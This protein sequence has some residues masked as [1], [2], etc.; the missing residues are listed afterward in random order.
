MEATQKTS[1]KTGLASAFDFIVSLVGMALLGGGL[2]VVLGGASTAAEAIY[3]P[4]TKPW[5]GVCFAISALI[6]IKKKDNIED[7]KTLALAYIS[8]AAMLFFGPLVFETL[9]YDEFHKGEFLN[10]GKWLILLV[11][12]WGALCPLALVGQSKNKER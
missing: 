7:K 6:F 2:G 11:G 9:F 1:G 10:Q 5:L 8:V 4:W 3:P 12:A